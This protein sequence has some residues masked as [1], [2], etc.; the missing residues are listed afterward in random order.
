LCKYE[1]A[2]EDFNSALI[3]CKDYSEIWYLKADSE[4]ALGRLEDA[5]K[6]Y[7]MVVKLEASNYDAWYDYGCALL[8]A[9]F[10]DHS[11][12]AF[13]KV[14]KYHPYWSEPYYE[15]AMIYFLKEEIESGIEMLEKAF[16]LSPEERCEYDFEKDWKK[17]LNFLIKR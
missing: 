7:E 10:F 5:I 12:N 3:L 14:I 17:I 9:K 2:L 16:E 13:D 4:H 11:L 1:N 6:S 8:D 15:K